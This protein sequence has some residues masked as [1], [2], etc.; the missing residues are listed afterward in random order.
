MNQKTYSAIRR[1]LFGLAVLS[2]AGAVVS[3]CHSGSGGGTASA[4]TVSGSIESVA[5]TDAQ[6]PV[7]V[8]QNGGTHQFGVKLR[9]GGVNDLSPDTQSWTLSNSSVGSI[10]NGG[11]FTATSVTGQSNLTVSGTYNGQSFSQS[12]NNA[13]K[14][15]N[16]VSNVVIELDQATR[17]VPL[18]DSST[19]RVY[20]TQNGGNK[21]ELTAQQFFLSLSNTAIGTV[22]GPVFTANQTNGVSDLIVDINNI[23][24]S[25]I[26]VTFSSA[27]TTGTGGSGG[28][29][30]GPH[31]TSITL[32][33]AGTATAGQAMPLSISAQRSN[34]TT[35][36]NAEDVLLQLNDPNQL[37]NG[38]ASVDAAGR[39]FFAN[40]NSLNVGVVALGRGPKNGDAIEQWSQTT[41]SAVINVSSGGTAAPNNVLIMTHLP[42]YGMVGEHLGFRVIDPTNGSDV[43]DQATYSFSPTDIVTRVVDENNANR[44]LEVI[45]PGLA[46]ITFTNG[47]KTGEFKFRGTTFNPNQQQRNSK[48][49]IDTHVRAGQPYK[50]FGSPNERRMPVLV[51]L[52]QCP[53]KANPALFRLDNNIQG[54][55]PTPPIRRFTDEGVEWALFEIVYPD[56][57]GTFSTGN[58]Q[59]VGNATN[60][61]NTGAGSNDFCQNKNQSASQSSASDNFR[62]NVTRDANF[63]RDRVVTD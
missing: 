61:I 2:V 39:M 8:L 13:V 14:V 53:S 49:V 26:Q 62:W 27:I 5:L 7:E 29:T 45:K 47:G 33:S 46:T 54:T 52:D 23:N 4:A 24:G 36:T 25:A 16:Q 42:A 10:N 18:S 58:F 60:P 15:T 48:D 30:S 35:T 50:T 51:N 38:I 43:T 57:T 31:F 9:V 37:E 59:Y 1:T 20:A 22:S 56:T 28:G 6:L 12:F 17:T 34:N 55:T 21:Q 32:S 11:L 63:R 44:A 3:G 19:I 41:K 40:T